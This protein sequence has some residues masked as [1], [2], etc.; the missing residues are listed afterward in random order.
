M[1]N[2]QHKEILLNLD[3]KNLVSALNDFLKSSIKKDIDKHF[4]LSG[5]AGTGKTTTIR[6][7]LQSLSGQDLKI[8]ITT[9][10]NKS[11]R[12]IKE[13][14]GDLSIPGVTLVFKTI[15]SL[16]NLR[17]EPSGAVKEL[18][19]KSDGKNDATSFDLI[20]ID[21]AS[22]LQNIVLTHL[23]RKTIFTGTKI[24]LLGDNEQ[25]PPVNEE[26]SAIWRMFDVNFR[27]AFRRRS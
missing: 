6:Y 22:M 4:L 1:K 19:D 16:L 11:L 21:E 10:T 23:D 17:L 7:F 2:K 9:P 15:Y 12:V 24:V 8:A 14:I 3:Q 20:V 13:S 25:L 26:E 18:V 27:L 5:Q